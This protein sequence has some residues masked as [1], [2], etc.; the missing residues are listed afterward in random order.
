MDQQYELEWTCMELTKKN[1]WRNLIQSAHDKQ[2][3]Q[4]TVNKDSTIVQ[5]QRPSDRDRNVY[6]AF[7]PMRRRQGI[8][9]VMLGYHAESRT[10]ARKKKEHIHSFL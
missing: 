10:R 2:S 9:I 4:T 7:L 6:L 3:K 8:I 5:N 1:L